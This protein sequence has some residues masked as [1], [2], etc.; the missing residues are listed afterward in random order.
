[1]N[2]RKLFI[3]V[4]GVVL[5]AL[6]AGLAA[7]AANNIRKPA[8][9]LPPGGTLVAT[10]VRPSAHDV[11]AGF[12][13]IWISS[14]PDR[15][16]ARID[17]TTDAVTA[18]ITLPDPATILAVGADSIWVT[19]APGNRVSRID[20]AT[21]RVVGSLTSGERGALG[22]TVFDG[23]VWVA[24][25][26]GDP[27]GSV[28]KID[29]AKMQVVDLIPIGDE[30]D[31][32]PTSMASGAGSIWVGVQNI[33]AVVRINPSTDTI[34]ATIPDGG[35]CREIV[36]DDQAIWVAGGC[37]PGPGVTRI[38]P[39]TNTVSEMSNASGNSPAI[40][41]GGDSVWYATTGNFL[42]RINVTTHRVVGRLRLPGPGFAATV[43][44]GFVWVT[45]E[46]DG[47]LFKVKPN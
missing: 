16:V 10:L 5:F 29:P 35:A 1:M 14:G 30:P 8:S 27:T 21:D 19:S 13:S 43:A 44:Y 22:I 32:G 15:T 17:P 38:D 7:L 20:P 6:L 11:V 31:G 18:V 23:Y 28:A 25:H 40:A 26:N 41:L 3:G 12:G 9:E 42:G 2:S 4:G 34:V 46:V 39:A 45:D 47:L 37:V 24:N 33:N 36:G